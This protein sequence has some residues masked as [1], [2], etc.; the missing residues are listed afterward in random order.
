MSGAARAWPAGQTLGTLRGTCDGIPDSVLATATLP[1]APRVARSPVVPA[2]RARVSPATSTRTSMSVP[3]S[4][5]ATVD[6]APRSAGA[7]DAGVC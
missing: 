7:A 1:W 3:M 6:K 4:L 2:R 5:A